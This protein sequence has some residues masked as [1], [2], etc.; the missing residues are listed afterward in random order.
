MLPMIRSPE[1]SRWGLV[2][3]E[4]HVDAGLS[5]VENHENCVFCRMIAGKQK[6]HLFLNEN[7]VTGLIS[8]EGHPLFVPNYHIE[9]SDLEK[10]SG[11]V[12]VGRAFE[13]AVRFVPIILEAYHASSINIV[14]NLGRDAGQEIPHVHVHAV[15]RFPGDNGMKVVIRGT[16]PKSLHG[17]VA[18][19]MSNIY[20]ESKK[21]ANFEAL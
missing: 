14:A 11:I 4:T 7:D 18:G 10:G 6:S 17:A 8:L 21:P 3:P 9:K 2:A 16:P 20:N 19:A 1:G 5:G 13:A 15:P 12:E